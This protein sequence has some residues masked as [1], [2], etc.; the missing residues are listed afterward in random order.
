[1]IRETEGMR[2][3]TSMPDVSAPV[4]GKAIPVA[5][6]AQTGM[7]ASIDDIFGAG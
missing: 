2:G 1:M 3:R 6:T 4:S 7:D 5:R